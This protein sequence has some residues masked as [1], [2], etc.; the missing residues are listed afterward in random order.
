ML[1]RNGRCWFQGGGTLVHSDTYLRGNIWGLRSLQ[2]F[3]LGALSIY[4]QFRGESSACSK[5]FALPTSKQFWNS[6]TLVTNAFRKLIKTKS[7]MCVNS[8]YLQNTKY[9]SVFYNTRDINLVVFEKIVS[10]SSSENLAKQFF[11]TIGKLYPSFKLM[12]L[13]KTKI[14]FI[15][16]LSLLKTQFTQWNF[17]K[18]YVKS[19]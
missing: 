9:F 7:G 1:W 5:D 3:L 15:R 18:I 6:S 17:F 11:K 8:K 14:I 19:F 12:Y 2:Y 4:V 10:P 13:H 16:N